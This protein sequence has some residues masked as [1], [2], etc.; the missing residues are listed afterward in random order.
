MKCW[1]NKGLASIALKDF[2]Q[3]GVCPASWNP[4]PI[5]NLGEMR[6]PHTS[7]GRLAWIWSSSSLQSGE[8]QSEGLGQRQWREGEVGGGET[9]THWVPALFS[10]KK[11]NTKS[12]SLLGSKVEGTTTYSPG[13]RRMRLLT[14]RRLMKLSER[15]REELARK[16]SRFKCTG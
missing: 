2:Y 9:T 6:G 8:G 5:T 10:E 12:P 4:N 7:S 15:A 14:S 16:K 11:R 1:A 13:G 3:K